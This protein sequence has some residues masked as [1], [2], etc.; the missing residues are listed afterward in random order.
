VNR[1]DIVLKEAFKKK[2]NFGSTTFNI[3]NEDLEALEK[4][5]SKGKPTA[6]D[7]EKLALEHREK[8]KEIKGEK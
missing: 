4:E 2:G 5:M 7:L 1:T 8:M 3:S 6:E